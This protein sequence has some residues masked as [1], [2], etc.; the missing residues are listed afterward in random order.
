MSWKGISKMQ[1]SKDFA[2]LTLSLLH[3]IWLA[4]NW[5]IRILC[6]VS[7]WFTS[8]LHLSCA[9]CFVLVWYGFYFLR[10]YN[11]CNLCW[12]ENSLLS[13]C[14]I[15]SARIIGLSFRIH[16]FLTFQVQLWEILCF[17]SLG[18]FYILWKDLGWNFGD[19][20]WAELSLTVPFSLN[21]F[22]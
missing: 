12:P 11:P 14:L 22:L 9:F 7:E 8:E 16:H 3:I 4:C 5:L 6:I 2:S 10:W 13:F 21:F 20:W 17:W 15:S 1:I 18:L 19:Q